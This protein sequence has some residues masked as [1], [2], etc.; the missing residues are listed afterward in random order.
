M[1]HRYNLGRYIPQLSANDT[2][3]LVYKELSQMMPTRWA[4]EPIVINGVITP[5]TVGPFI[6]AP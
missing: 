3:G 4:P 2:I 1:R 6:G 5:I